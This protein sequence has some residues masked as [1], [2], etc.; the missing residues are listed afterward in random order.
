MSYLFRCCIQDLQWTDGQ[1]VTV[2]DLWLYSISVSPTS[3]VMEP[4]TYDHTVSYVM[5]PLTYDHHLNVWPTHVGEVMRA[6]K[7][8]PYEE[9]VPPSQL[10]GLTD[11]S[12]KFTKN[13]DES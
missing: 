4:L 8:V 3:C 13:P 9:E 2:H 11:C 7:M 10:E 6:R 1:A 12:Y 5:Q